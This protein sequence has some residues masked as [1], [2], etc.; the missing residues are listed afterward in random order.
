VRDE[1]ERQRRRKITEEI[2]EWRER[3]IVIELCL[4]YQKHRFNA[5]D[6]KADLQRAPATTHL[7]NFLPKNF[8]NVISTSPPRPSCSVFSKRLALQRFC[9]HYLS[10]LFNLYF[11]IIGHAKCRYTTLI[12]HYYS[13]SYIHH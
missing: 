6:C 1:K 3:R 7:Y 11:Q 10:P 9:K 8:L 2:R 4:L 13:N 5:A 12:V